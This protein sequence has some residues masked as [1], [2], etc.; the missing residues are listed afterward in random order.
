MASLHDL[1]STK[2]AI[3][4]ALL[5][6][7]AASAAD[8][9]T[10]RIGISRSDATMEKLD[11]SSER[12]I[13]SE[14]YSAAAAGDGNLE[15]NDIGM[16]SLG[17]DALQILPSQ[18]DVAVPIAGLMLPDPVDIKGAIAVNINIFSARRSGAGHDDWQRGGCCGLIRSDNSDIHAALT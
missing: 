16:I 18:G 15:T 8:P 4:L 9:E 2:V 10:I 6:A 5:T 13:V 17:A 11:Q 12:V 7:I 1:K 3:A 14:I